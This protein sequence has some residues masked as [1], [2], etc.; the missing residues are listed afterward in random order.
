M[1]VLNKTTALAVCTFLTAGMAWANDECVDA[2]AISDGDTAFDTT[3][4]TGEGDI[5]GD[6]GAG[7]CFT[8]CGNGMWFSYTAS[9]DGTATFSTC[10]QAF[11]TDLAVLDSCGGA[12]LACSGDAPG[13]AGY[14]SECALSV[15]AGST[16]LV[17]VGGYNGVT[18]AGTLTASYTPPSATPGDECDTADA[19]VFVDGS[20]AID[21][22]G[23]T[24]SGNNPTDCTNTFGN[25]ANDMWATY[26]ATSS[27]LMTVST[28]PDFDTDLAVYA[29]CGTALACDGDGGDGLCQTYDSLISG[30]AV[31]AGSSYIIRVGGWGA[32]DAGTGTVDISVV[33]N[34]ECANAYAMG[35]GDNAFD[36]TGST[37][38]ADP[39]ATDCTNSFGNMA[40]D[41][42][43]TYTA[44]ADGTLSL[45]TCPDFDTDLALWSGACDALSIVACDGDGGD[46]S[47]NAY[48]SAIYDVAVLAGESFHI[49]IGGWGS[50]DAGTGTLA[51]T[52][53][54]APPPPATPGDE[55]DT[56]DA[57]VFVDG[58]NA[59]DT[60]GMTTSGNNPTDCTNAFGAMANDM[61]ATYTATAD[62]FMTVSTCPAF[63]T[64]LAV[65]ADCDTV[66]ACDGDSGDGS[67]HT[68]DSL[69]E[70]IAVTAGS[71][72]IIRVG[73]WGAADA[74]TGTVD[75]SIATSVPTGSCCLG[76]ENCMDDVGEADCAAAGGSYNGDDSLCDAD[77]CPAP[78]ETACDDAGSEAW[79]ADVFGA[80]AAGGVACGGGGLTVGNFYAI[81][82]LVENDTVINC[83]EF[84]YVNT[85]SVVPT[86]IRLYSDANGGAPDEF[87]MGS[88]IAE[89]STHLASVGN[90]GSKIVGLEGG[91]ITVAAG[92]NLVVEVQIGPIEGY[93]DGWATFASDA[94]ATSIS[95][96]EVWI[97]SG[98]C[99][100]TSYT[101]LSAIGFADYTW[102]VRL[103]GDLDGGG[104]AADVDGNGDV[105][106]GDVLAVLSA[107][108][109]TGG[110][111]DVD[112]NGDVGFGDVLAILSAW[113]PC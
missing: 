2:I 104:C 6:C 91:A 70:N 62:G 76:V 13:C 8:G 32:A 48:D 79:P 12:V 10:N 89:A 82:Y 77:S 92:T 30:V 35:E 68:Y 18:G 107:W 53:D 74:G 113:G 1:N 27:G 100:L 3:G 87:G 110:A 51:I 73:G 84:M 33:D 21:T 111:E 83:V 85:G 72:Y 60:T 93:H 43:Y 101:A 26:T 56:A 25:M 67:C 108:G 36:T 37:T 47:C 97:K 63:D 71:N 22:T 64:D 75:I 90:D 41:A 15:T 20:N 29:D 58:S 99:G 102:S 98:P 88:P 54:S 55:C 95:S 14:T 86:S 109:G 103:H 105:G 66:L 61:W 4:M 94:A 31:S 78:P 7:C 42:W 23:M 16:Y 65:Y 50:G 39:A 24:T 52:L 9:G 19:I 44:A 28:C 57:F 106:F 112:G 34:D 81:P 46:G 69:V 80:Y 59:I 40:N 49:Q 38:G 11:D 45:V 17:C 96:G 5:V